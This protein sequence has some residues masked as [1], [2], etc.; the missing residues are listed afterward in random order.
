[1]FDAEMCH[2]EVAVERAREREKLREEAQADARGLVSAQ[3][4][5]SD[6]AVNSL[7][8]KKGQLLTTPTC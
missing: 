3:R 2:E 7:K 6:P 8:V 5:S 1:M 4:T